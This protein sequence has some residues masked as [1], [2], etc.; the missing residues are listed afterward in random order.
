MDEQ[1]VQLRGDNEYV[2]KG[3]GSGFMV[4]DPWRGTRYG[5]A[6]ER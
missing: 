2:H 3:T 5:S 6:A 1:P 4:V